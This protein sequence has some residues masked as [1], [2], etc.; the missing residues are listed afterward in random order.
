MRRAVSVISEVSDT[1]KYFF[2][3]RTLLYLSL[4]SLTSGEK[5]VQYRTTDFT[6]FADVGGR[7]RCHL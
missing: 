3:T 7:P 4:T 5:R 1:R 6:D 2:S